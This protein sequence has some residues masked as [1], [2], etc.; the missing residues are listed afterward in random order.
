MNKKKITI[1]SI[2]AVVLLVAIYFIGR[3]VATPDSTIL[4]DQVVEN[5]SFK[6]ADLKYENGVSTLN[7]TVA[8]D[9]K[10]DINLSTITVKLT[11][12]G[13]VTEMIGYIG[14]VL[15]SENETVMT[16]SI[17]KDITNSEKLEYIIN[18]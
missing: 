12:S 1:I 11:E 3:S 6:N 4:K 16:A 17:D 13:K 15:K 9:T 14:P 8:N 5:L 18:K 2:V 10:E 7:V